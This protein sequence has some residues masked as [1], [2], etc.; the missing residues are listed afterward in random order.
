MTGLIGLLLILAGAMSY[1]L[2]PIC[3]VAYYMGISKLGAE[4]A[5]VD[6]A[7]WEE[8]RPRMTMRM[9]KQARQRERLSLFIR[10]REYLA[11]GDARISALGDRVRMLDRAILIFGV[12]FL[13]AALRLLWL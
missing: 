4:L 11:Y 12:T 7:I 9:G 2:V 3:V 1:I 8:I 6:S 10:E 5:K 13:A